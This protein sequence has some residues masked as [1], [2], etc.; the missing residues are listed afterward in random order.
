MS[1]QDGLA[2]DADHNGTLSQSDSFE[3]A[4]DYLSLK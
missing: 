4:Q 1:K 3:D 2:V